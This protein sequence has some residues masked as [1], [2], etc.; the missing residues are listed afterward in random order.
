MGVFVAGMGASG[1]ALA[2]R[3]GLEPLGLVYGVVNRVSASGGVSVIGEQR[4]SMEAHLDALH[5]A[6]QR[7]TEQARALGANGVAGV[8]I[9]LRAEAISGTAFMWLLE[10][11]ATGT[12]VRDAE[13]QTE[14]SLWTATLSPQEIWAMRQAGYAPKTVEVGFGAVFANGDRWLARRMMAGQATGIN[15]ANIEL[16]WMSE[17]VQQARRL[18]LAGVEA[19]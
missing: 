9:E 8:T 11:R 4:R 15:L 16:S 13:A 6:L 2:R 10:C 17:A 3:A 19:E 7:M 12:A 5:A 1:L 18:A 14:A